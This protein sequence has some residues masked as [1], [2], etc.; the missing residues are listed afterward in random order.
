MKSWV[1]MA[2]GI[3][4]YQKAKQRSSTF[5]LFCF[6]ENTNLTTL[7]FEINNRPMRR[8]HYLKWTNQRLAVR[9]QFE[10][11][12]KVGFGFLLTRVVLILF[13]NIPVDHGHTSPE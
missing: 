2:L 12:D 11:P 4:Q 6:S 13:K 1:E 10:N 7:F 3:D 5:Y 9:I 8:P